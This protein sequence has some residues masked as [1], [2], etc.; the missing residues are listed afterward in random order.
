MTSRCRISPLHLGAGAAVVESQSGFEV[1]VEV[2]VEVAVEL[3]AEVEVEGSITR[4]GISPGY[5]PSSTLKTR[6]QLA[7]EAEST[8]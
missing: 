4:V 7:K 6:F 1:S 5:D 8:S 3:E 2:G